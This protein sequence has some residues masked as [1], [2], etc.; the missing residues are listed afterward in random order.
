[1]LKSGRPFYRT[2]CAGFLAVCGVVPMMADVI[3]LKNG[4]V[5]LAGRAWVV[6]DSVKYETPDGVKSLSRT[7]VE[8]LVKESAPAAR[9]VRVTPEAKTE[10]KAPPP[11]PKP[12]EKPALLK[13]PGRES[14]K[15]VPEE[16][17]TSLK[18]RLAEAPD[19]AQHRADLV[20]AL[21]LRAGF[22]LLRGEM[23]S[24]MQCC[25]EALALSPSDGPS[26]TN[27]ALIHFEKGA[28]GDAEETLRRVAALGGNR[29]PA[30]HYLLGEAYY[31]QDKLPAA[32]EAWR[33]SLQIEPDKGIQ[34]RLDKALGELNTHAEMEKQATRHFI[35]RYD[36]KVA[37]ASLGQAILDH[38]ETGYRELSRTLLDTPPETI[39]II[40][41]PDQSY[42]DITRS[43]LW[44][45]AMYDGKIRVPIKGVTGLT[46]ELRATLDHELAHAFLA[47]TVGDRCPAWFNEG[48][49]Q[50]VEGRRAAQ[51]RKLLVEAK[52]NKKLIPLERL[53][54]AF[55]GLSP[56]EV[57]IAYAQSLAAVD[58]LQRK[59]GPS[60]VREVL[61]K[62]RARRPFGES[63]G[64]VIRLGPKD[65][66]RAWISSF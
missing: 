58:Y 53:N 5:I 2:V 27:L 29:N 8:D 61:A 39:T 19:N 51:G 33:Q 10:G 64:E 17:L 56:A 41:Y 35:L 54:Q 31:A 23:E 28:Y 63:L 9:F 62:L 48:I 34:E 47:I 14:G 3:Y 45:G 37:D 38:L 50:M 30:V 59:S 66:E 52:R 15:E 57:P 4:R 49:A 36:K 1:M 12:K 16:T 32:V 44:S 43:P 7:L 11:G 24:A 18:A 65:F 55:S 22:L 46:G 40:L 13:F 26:L 20:T 6:D 42:F 21:N 25:K 60:A